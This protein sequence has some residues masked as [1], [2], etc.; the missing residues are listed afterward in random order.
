MC[1]CVCVYLYGGEGVNDCKG[2]AYANA[3]VSSV[4]CA[5]ICAL[6]MRK[7]KYICLHIYIYMYID[8]SVCVCVCIL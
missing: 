2:K 4:G 1:V 7:N 5:R 8:F 3:C 6:F